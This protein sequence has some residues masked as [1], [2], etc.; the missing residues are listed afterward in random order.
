[1]ILVVFV[2]DELNDDLLFGLDLEHFDD[3]TEERS[4]LPVAAEG[5][6]E[7]V[8]L[9]GLVDER[10]RREAE[11]L[12]LPIGVLVDLPPHDL[13]HQILRVRPPYALRR[14]VRTVRHRRR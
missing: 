3:Q 13:L 1:M 12:L 11:A 2:F 4:G 6:A 8:D 5:A 14:R 10:L 9:H 7:V